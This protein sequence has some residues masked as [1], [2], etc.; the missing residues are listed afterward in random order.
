[1]GSCPPGE[2]FSDSFCLLSRVIWRVPA[3]FCEEVII[4]YFLMGLGMCVF[5]VICVTSEYTFEKEEETW[6]CFE[7]VFTS[8]GWS[9]LSPALFTW[10]T[11]SGVFFFFLSGENV[12]NIW[13]IIQA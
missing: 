4:Y 11:A 8:A 6:L 10:Y 5:A 13:F 3:L 12:A 1:M 2:R 7:N 9:V